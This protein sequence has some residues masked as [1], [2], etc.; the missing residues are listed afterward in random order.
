MKLMAVASPACASTQSVHSR[1]Y[2]SHADPSAMLDRDEVTA[3]AHGHRWR[4]DADRGR[5]RQIGS[6]RAARRALKGQ[7]NHRSWDHRIDALTHTH[8]CVEMQLSGGWLWHATV[9]VRRRHVDVSRS[10]MPSKRVRTCGWPLA[11]LC[12]GTIPLEGLSGMHYTA[13]RQ[14]AKQGVIVQVHDGSLAP[15]RAP[16]PEACHTQQN[17]QQTRHAAGSRTQ[18]ESGTVHTNKHCVTLCEMLEA[19]NEHSRLKPREA[20]L[21]AH[22]AGEALGARRLA[23]APCKATSPAS[24]VQAQGRERPPRLPAGRLWRRRAALDR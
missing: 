7:K 3:G 8:S 16:S 15:A 12:T 10:P 1:T 6:T 4:S 19:L 23:S 22:L 20:R 5:C 11:H 2:S 18:T 21:S 9:R 13:P 17:A 14:T 24:A